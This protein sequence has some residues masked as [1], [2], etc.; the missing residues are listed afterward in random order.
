MNTNIETTAFADAHPLY[1]TE[2][3]YDSIMG[4]I[5]PDLTVNTIGKLDEKYAGETENDRVARLEQYEA[6]FILFAQC[7]EDLDLLY[8][9]E[10]QKLMNEL[11]EMAVGEEAKNDT[12][13]LKE[14]EHSMDNDS[15]V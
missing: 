3:F 6:A 7:L 15:D 5:E 4:E 10:M 8:Q 1:S 14:I 11:K 12:E 2:W 9:G 13:G